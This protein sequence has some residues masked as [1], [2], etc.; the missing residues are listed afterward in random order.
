MKRRPAT[1]LLASSAVLCLFASSVLWLRPEQSLAE[2]VAPVVAYS[3]DQ[4]PGTTADDASGN[5]NSATV[6]GSTWTVGRFSSGLLL[7]GSTASYTI[8][9]PVNNFPRT[10]ITVEFWMRTSDVLNQGTPV[11]YAVPSSHNEFRISD[12]NNLQISV[13]TTRSTGPT[14]V[15]AN[16]GNWHHL[17]VT[18]RSSDGQVEIYKDGVLAYTANIA[19]G[20]V[21]TGGGSLVL[22][23]DQETV[24]GGFEQVQAFRGWLDEVRI[25]NL[26]LSAAEIRADLSAPINLLDTIPPAITNVVASPGRTTATITWIT[27]ELAN[28]QVEYGLTPSYG[29]SSPLDTSRIA[30]HAGTLSGLQTNTTYHYRVRSVDAAGNVTLSADAPFRTLT[31]TAPTGVKVAFIGDQGLGPNA[32]AVLQMIRNEGA[33]FVVHSGDFDYADD[34]DAWDQ[35]ISAV[36]G[37]GFPYFASI[38][39]HEVNPEV[40]TWPRYQAKLQ[41][42]LGRITNASCVGDLGVQTVCLY[43]GLLLVFT[44]PGLGSYG[45]PSTGHEAFLRDQLAQTNFSWRISSWHVVQQ[46]MQVGEKPDEAGWEVYEEARRGGAILATA[47]D[48]TYARTYLMSDFQNQVVAS[49]SSLLQVE[50]G[51]S[52]A[53]VSGLGGNSIRPQ[54][55][56]A[57]WWAAI[58]T[59]TQGANFGALFCTFGVNDQPNRA[60]CYFKDISGRQPDQFDVLSRVA[61][62]TQDGPEFNL[63][64][65]APGPF[66]GSVTPGPA[67]AGQP[68]Q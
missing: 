54:L 65:P 17:A 43:K 29:S 9:N 58:Y 31:S 27:T 68:R 48:H 32:T 59:E 42:R 20:E 10:E 21:I 55:L 66:G 52:F 14:G 47:H 1:F 35:Q 44:A 46:L 40:P 19:A 56:D 26:V 60:S 28:S 7:D 30:W 6:F 38:G 39:N 12:Y 45:F 15:S 57:R 22:G 50:K 53:F 49:T 63:T 25:Y 5:G 61:A 62:S 2:T 24:G 8:K 16:D 11:S 34:P 23:Q 67:A 51:K 36:L 3:F 33:H 64:G 18:W 13:K 41:A 37:S 4:G